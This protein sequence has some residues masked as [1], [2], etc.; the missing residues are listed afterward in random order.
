MDDKLYRK[1][2]ME[3][4]NT[5]KRCI[6]ILAD[7][8]RRVFKLIKFRDSIKSKICKTSASL[9]ENDYKDNLDMEADYDL[10]KILEETLFEQETALTELRNTRC[11][12]IEMQKEL[13]SKRIQ[14]KR[15]ARDHR[16]L[17][18]REI[19]LTK[20]LAEVKRECRQMKITSDIVND[21]FLKMAEGECIEI[22]K[23]R[24]NID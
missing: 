10:L 9:D 22:L 6:K 20:K 8:A 3:N 5:E 23:K 15:Q 16:K 11:K 7:N 1:A 4:L 14:M 18:T 21:P 12:V 19:L 24:R 17:I 2:M 13:K